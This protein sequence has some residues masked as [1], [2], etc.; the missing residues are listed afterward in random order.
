MSASTRPSTAELLR[1]GDLPHPGE[2]VVIHL[3]GTDHG[4]NVVVDTTDG[5][6]EYKVER[7]SAWYGSERCDNGDT[8]LAGNFGAL[9]GRLLRDARKDD[10]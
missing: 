6:A 9:L 1:R 4:C 2:H 3:T 7:T 5:R 8:K 10:D